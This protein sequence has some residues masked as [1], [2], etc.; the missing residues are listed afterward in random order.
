MSL[1]ELIAK[2]KGMNLKEELNKLGFN[3]FDLLCA[4]KTSV[5][6]KGHVTRGELIEFAKNDDPR[7]TQL[8]EMVEDETAGM[9]RKY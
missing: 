8:L 2:G 6:F 7:I 5:V 4:T 9:P 1:C 3:V